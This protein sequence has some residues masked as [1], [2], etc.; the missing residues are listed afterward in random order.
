[1]ETWSETSSESLSDAFLNAE[2]LVLPDCTD[3]WQHELESHA[4]AA[5]KPSGHATQSGKDT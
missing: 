5:M 4:T 1:M 3:T 2:A